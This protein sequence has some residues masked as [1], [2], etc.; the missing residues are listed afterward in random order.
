MKRVP[1][2]LTWPRVVPV[3]VAAR[4]LEAA[5]RAL[6]GCFE[7]P[8]QSLPLEAQQAALH[9]A[10]DATTRASVLEHYMRLDAPGRQ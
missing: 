6:D 1:L 7:E 9:A 3:E 4:T 10:L 8:P 5:H 2:P